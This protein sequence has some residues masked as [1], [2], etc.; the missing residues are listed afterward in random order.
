M[1]PADPTP[2]RLLAY[3][4]GRVSVKLDADTGIAVIRVRTFRPDDSYRLINDLLALG[5]GRVNIL[6]QRAYDNSLRLARQ[7]LIEAE[8]ALRT[9]QTAM[10]SFRQGRRTID[11][12]AIGQAQIGVVSQLQANLAQARA[13]R[14]AMA[15]AIA[16]SSPQARAV[17]AR[18]G[19]LEGQV[20]VESARL[21]GGGAAI[22][23]NVGDYQGLQLRQQFASKLYDDAAASLQR[24]REQAIR[25]QLFIVRVV[26]PNRP[27]KALYPK[28]LRIVGTAFVVLTL[29]YALGWL[30]VRRCTRTY[31]LS[32][33]RTG[34]WTDY[35]QVRS[36]LEDLSY[37]KV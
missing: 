19:A 17:D 29:C 6:N 2:E 32:D 35:D 27:V 26:E 25:Q 13:Q 12:V 21:A 24:A 16:P 8:Q 10:T 18:V 11:P 15:G 30:I 7:Q 36:G 20:A 34:D 37:P 3:Y 31:R 4:R 14:S 9:S 5:E 33:K 28:S 1:I 23:S 22:A